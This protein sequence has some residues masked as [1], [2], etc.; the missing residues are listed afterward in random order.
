MALHLS[1]PIT[2]VSGIGPAKAKLLKRIGITY[3]RD[4]VYAFPRRY[5]FF[6]DTSAI[7]DVKVGE[8]MIIH[9]T[10]KEVKTEWGWRGKRRILRTFAT[11]TDGTGD[12]HAT[13]YNVR[14]LAEQLWQ[15]RPLYLAGTVGVYEGKSELPTFSMQMPVLEYGNP[16]DDRT[17]T[18]LITPVYP[19]TVGV[20][21]RFL[22]YT[23]KKVLPLIDTLPEYLPED[24]RRRHELVGIHAALREI[25]FPTTK[26][27]LSAAEKR[28]RFDELFFLQLSALVRKQ[29]MHHKKALALSVSHEAIEQF[30]ARLP[31]PL[32]KAQQRVVGEVTSDIQKS[33]P[34]N[35]LLQGDV[36]S[37]KSMVALVAAWATL[38]AGYQCLYIAPTEILARQQYQFLAQ[39]LGPERVALLIGALSSVEK[40]RVKE[41]LL[42]STPLCVV[43]TH[44]LLTDD[45]RAQKVALAI[46][47]EQHRFGVTQRWTLARPG[48]LHQT[49]TPHLLSMT[50]TPIPRTLSLSVYGDLDISVL[51]E[52]PPGRKPITTRVIAPTQREEILLFVLEQLHHGRQAYVI[53]PL[54]EAS[55]KL[56]AKSARETYEEMQHYFPGIAVGLVHGQMK[57][58]EK[59][60]VMRQFA[61]GAVQLLVS[62]AVIEVGVN[63]P[64]ATCMIIEGAERFGLAQLH[65]FRGRIGRGTEESFC[66][67]FPTTQQAV[68]NPRLTLLHQTVDGFTI[69]EEDLRMRGPGEVYGVEQSGFAD[70]QVAS[71]LDYDTIQATR[72]EGKRLLEE[73]PSLT[74]YPILQKKVAQKNNL[75]HFE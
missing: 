72:S 24:I 59:D 51:D 4:L 19:E 44:A 20:T 43:G 14:Y 18:A 63:V 60:S 49:T 17:H 40:K 9:G 47:D 67:L 12:I 32:T 64:N 75:I 71:L 69:A 39:Y 28:L 50:A 33:V 54:V 29:R 38:E 26:E 25:H 35:R 13:W 23:L 55:D 45:I 34:M 58:S 36:G 3:I 6:S 37:G 21:S 52:M 65:Q 62:T 56:Q 57:S 61:A 15:G 68:D 70:L 11:I 7:K 10:V 16:T 8:R 22:R 66:F 5:D 31:Y 30:I 74:H 27:K 42:T 48:A 53:A 46:I 2:D 73:D 1:S 41:K